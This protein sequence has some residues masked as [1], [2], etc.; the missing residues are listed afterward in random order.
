MQR[1]LAAFYRNLAKHL[2]KDRVVVID[3]D[4]PVEAV[5]ARIWTACENAM[6]S[7]A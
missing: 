3:G 7:S 5:H 4:G 6:S 2:P 1:S